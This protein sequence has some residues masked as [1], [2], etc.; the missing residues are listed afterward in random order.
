MLFVWGLEFVVHGTI[1]L[2]TPPPTALHPSFC[3]RACKDTKGVR[4]LHSLQFRNAKTARWTH[5][6]S[7]PHRFWDRAFSHKQPH[8]CEMRYHIAMPPLVN[9]ARNNLTNRVHVSPPRLHI[10]HCGIPTRILG[11]TPDECMTLV[12]T[13]LA[14]GCCACLVPCT[15]KRVSRGHSC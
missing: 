8:T 10:I 9:K 12:R 7:H 1:C 5:T 3:P 14:S 4:A 11:V 13:I 15:I 6:A 2:G